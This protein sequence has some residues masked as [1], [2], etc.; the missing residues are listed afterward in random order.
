MRYT[1]DASSMQV[2]RSLAM[3]GELSG[4]MI[5]IR[6]DMAGQMLELP[7]DKKM[8]VGREASHCDYV[9][10]DARVSRKHLEITYVAA[11]KNYVVVDISKNGT[12]LSDGTRL[13][14][15]KEYILPPMTE[16]RLGS[17]GNI[18]KLK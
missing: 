14:S 8:L 13:V 10:S 4:A 2:T 11:L 3:S 15:N 9:I 7:S 1:N 6:G 5:C 16:F 17:S 18:Y 12:F